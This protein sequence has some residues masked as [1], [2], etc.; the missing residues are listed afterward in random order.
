MHGYSWC[1]ALIFLLTLLVSLVFFCGLYCKRHRMDSATLLMYTVSFLI[2][3][4]IDDR[5]S[6][7][8]PLS[9]VI[10]LSLDVGLHPICDG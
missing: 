5:L 4:L 9:A 3:P 1:S 7:V 6:I 2:A 10:L 8:I